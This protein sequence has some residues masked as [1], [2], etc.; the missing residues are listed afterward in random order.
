MRNTLKSAEI[1][2]NCYINSFLILLFVFFFKYYIEIL[3]HLEL[4]YSLSDELY[5]YIYITYLF[6]YSIHF[7]LYLQG[8]TIEGLFFNFFSSYFKYLEAL[9]FIIWNITNW[10]SYIL[11]LVIWRKKNFLMNL[12]WSKHQLKSQ[13]ISGLNYN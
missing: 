9:V 6:I 13:N 1:R 7:H 12:R 5:I 3:F 8:W 10:F 11:I 2:C 4:F